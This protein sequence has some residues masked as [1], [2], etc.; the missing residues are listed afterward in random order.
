MPPPPPPPGAPPPPGPP[1]PSFSAPVSK[2]GGGER[3]DLLKQIQKGAQLKKTVTNDRS[4]PILGANKNSSNGGG[5]PASRGVGQNTSHDSGPA[6]G[7]L[8]GIGGLFSGGMP[9]LKKTVGGVKTGRSNNGEDSFCLTLSW[10]WSWIF[11]GAATATPQNKWG[12]QSKLEKPPLSSSSSSLVRKAQMTVKYFYWRNI[13][14]RVSI[15][16]ITS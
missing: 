2:G 12:S 7:P 9:T 3:K 5:A 11:A 6:P 10:Y 8:P 16:I 14:M 13:P 1:P 4:G 15:S